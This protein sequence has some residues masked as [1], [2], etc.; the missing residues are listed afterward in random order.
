METGANS[1]NRRV[2]VSRLHE[3]CVKAM[4]SSGMKETDAHI[5]AEVLVTTDTWGTF[6][7]GTKHLGSYLR[8]VRAGGT[9]PVAVPQVIA[10]GPSW[11]MVDGHS[12]MAMV[13]AYTG[14]ELAIVKA[15]QS[16]VGYVGVKHS[17]HFGAAG[18]YASM[19]L[20]YDMLGLAM[21]NVDANM[22]VPGARG[23]VIGNNPLAYAVPAGTEFPI[24]LDMALSTVA[25]GK[26]YAAQDL[27][28]SIPNTWL[29][30]G[31]GLPTTDIGGYPRVGSLLPMAG[32]KGYGL[33]LLVEVLAAVL[34]GAAMTSQVRLWGSEWDVPTDEGHAFIAIDVGAIMP[35]EV[36]QERID[37]L[38][39]EIHSAPRAK[40]ASR[41]YLPGEMEWEKRTVAL[42]QGI[43]LPDDV[44]ASLIKMAHE[45]GLDPGELF[46]QREAVR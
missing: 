26:I 40:G 31:D 12:A 6:T 43:D 29:V 18:F 24:M 10:E 36:F 14:M 41:I 17:T 28:T 20:Q 22:T 34:T 13:S 8:R 4:V 15:Q 2:P 3:F 30:D 7:H 42:E 1:E 46:G 45:V 25:A 32:H 33:A 35:L 16:G 37:W 11:A 9:D 27:G 39:R 19:A 23:N 21:S 38:V 5:T 44:R